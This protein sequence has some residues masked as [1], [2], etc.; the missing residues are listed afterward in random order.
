MPRSSRNS[1]SGALSGRSAR[2]RAA[3]DLTVQYLNAHG[4]EILA[5]NVFFTMIGEL[6]IV[7]RCG[8]IIC[9]VE[10]RSRRDGDLGEP[11]ETVGS[12]KQ[13]KLR[14]L[15]QLYLDR[16]GLQNAARFDVAS[17][18]WKPKPRVTYIE[19]AFT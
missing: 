5:R 3:E 16:H 13:R 15:A 12:T 2:G 6:D 7:A 8:E 1:Q 14:T 10:V 11:H 4:Y 18:T 17:V 19:D 9:F